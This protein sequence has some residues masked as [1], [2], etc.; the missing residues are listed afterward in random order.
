MAKVPRLPSAVE[1]APA[2]F[3]TM[4]AHAPSLRESFFRFYGA[5]W[6]SEHAG[7][8]LKELLRVRTARTVDCFL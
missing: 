1:G 3:Q 4:F 6:S 5:I 2:S 7:P 8:E